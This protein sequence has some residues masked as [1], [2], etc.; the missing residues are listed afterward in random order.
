M[1]WY[2]REKLHSGEFRKKD[3]VISIANNGGGHNK[4]AVVINNSST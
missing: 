1:G 4:N 3:G 2:V